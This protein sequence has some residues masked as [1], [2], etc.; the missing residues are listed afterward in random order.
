MKKLPDVLK[1]FSLVLVLSFLSNSCA[2]K[3]TDWVNP[4]LEKMPSYQAD[5][6][7][8]MYISQCK[9]EAEIKARQMYSMRYC[10]S[11]GYCDM[12]LPSNQN[13]RSMILGQILGQYVADFE[14]F[15][16]ECMV[17]NGFFEVEVENK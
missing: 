14:N 10:D 11:T 6:I 16:K 8:Q 4:S 13:L 9:R 7:K 17:R 15:F 12:P 1:L 2:M 5:Q 3:K